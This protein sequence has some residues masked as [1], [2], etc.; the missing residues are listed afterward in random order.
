MVATYVYW[1]MKCLGHENVRVLDGT[2]EDWAAASLP[3]TKESKIRPSTNYTCTPEHT[4][5]LIATYEYIKSSQAQIIDAR[6]FGEFKEG[7]IPGAVNIPYESVLDN[8]TIKNGAALKHVFARLSKDRP[9]AVY[10][11]TY[12]KTSVVWFALELMGYDA[13]LYSWKDWMASRDTIVFYLTKY[14]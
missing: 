5:D 10:A 7:S 9:V 3:T 8:S 2:I 13:K 11:D 12:I 14:T 4:S 6:P 1:I